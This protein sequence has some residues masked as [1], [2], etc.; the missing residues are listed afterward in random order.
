MKADMEYA[1]D[2]RQRAE[3]QR[4]NLSTLLPNQEH[5]QTLQPKGGE[6]I[7]IHEHVRL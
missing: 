2:V 4:K 7:S 5:L 6:F 1:E 3:N